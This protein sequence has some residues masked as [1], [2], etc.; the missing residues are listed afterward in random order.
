MPERRSD[1]NPEQRAEWEAVLAVLRKNRSATLIEMSA[2]SGIDQEKLEGI[3]SELE[4]RKLVTITKQG[5][6][7]R[8]IVTIKERAFAARAY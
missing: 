4:S 5:G 7:L 3:I 6:P 2:L 1:Q 8:D